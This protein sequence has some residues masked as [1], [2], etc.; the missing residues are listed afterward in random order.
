VAQARAGSAAEGIA[1]RFA[2]RLNWTAAPPRAGRPPGAGAVLGDGAVDCTPA[3]GVRSHLEAWW[4]GGGATRRGVATAGGVAALFAGYLRDVPPPH[5]DEAAFLLDRYRAEDWGWLRRASGVFAFAVVDEA[6]DRCVLGVDRLGVR[7]LFYAC[8]AARVSFAGTL[9]ATLVLAGPREPDHDTLQELMVLGFPLTCR[10]LA[11]G[12][13]RVP[14]G[15]LLDI[16]SGTPRP[17]T[18]WSIA[19]VA[20]PR[21]SPSIE[22]FLDES[23]ER[24]RHALTPLLARSEPT[25]L[26]LLSS[27][28]DSRRLLLEAHALGAPL[29]V[30]TSM[31]PYARLAGTTI[32][33]AVTG[34][35]C[36][37]L[38]LSRRLVPYPGAHSA[39]DACRAR[40]VRDVLLD[41]Q[42]FGRDHVWAVPLAAALVPTDRQANLDGIAG[43]TFFNNPFYRLPRPLWGHWRVEGA[44][45]DAIAPDRGA[46]DRPWG[47][48]LSRSFSGRLEAALNALPEGPNRLSFFY[49]L[50]RTRAVVGML[51]Y[52]LLDLR[53]ESFCPY[54]D[55]DVM[56]H[57]LALDPVLKGERR[58]QRLALQRHFPD[59]ADVPSS[60]SAPSE[61]PPIY[62]Q[63]MPYVDPDRPGRLTFADVAG[64]L[65]GI[66][67]GGPRPEARDLAFAV[68]SGL[69]LGGLGGGWR[70]PR[71]RDLLQARR[72][73]A[74]CAGPAGAVRARDGALAWLERWRTLSADA[75]A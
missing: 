2:G 42:V 74:L 14:P 11:G 51:P 25:T 70:E 39:L 53:L 48:R 37:R 43:D 44:V 62:L 1:V 45:L 31:W 34:A 7:P 68:L 10:T 72:A 3:G 60:H 4:P 19:E 12:I 56:D 20:E 47:D 40:A 13:E 33:P 61:V 36:R 16:R 24:L 67:R 22:R 66:G 41:Y 32:E 58:L 49:L 54:L 57:A 29:A 35:L 21:P 71:L 55:H 75:G 28:F 59:L 27:G 6:A 26:C 18:Y 73:R 23:R 46:V 9:A 52:G 17:T 69:G 5:G 8:D 65:R 63:A 30:V 38:G 50:G 15:T 64:L